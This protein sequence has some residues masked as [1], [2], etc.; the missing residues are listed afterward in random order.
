MVVVPALIPVTTPIVLTVPTAGVLLLQEPPASGF[1]RVVVCPTHIEVPPTIEGGGGFTVNDVVAVAVHNPPKPID[2][3]SFTAVNVY[4][5]VP[6][7][8]PVMAGGLAMVDE[9]PA[10]PVHR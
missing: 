2:I 7:P 10:G 1:D 6:G 9:Y 8:R 5:Y 4:V 3:G